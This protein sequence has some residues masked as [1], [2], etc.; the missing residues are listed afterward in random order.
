MDKIMIEKLVEEVK[1]NNKN[2]YIE[3]FELII[4]ENSYGIETIALKR[5]YEEINNLKGK[6][7]QWQL[8]KNKNYLMKL[9]RDLKTFDEVLSFILNNQNSKNAPKMQKRTK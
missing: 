9:D 2:E 3:I 5:I 4:N 8:K 6:K 7:E 1:I